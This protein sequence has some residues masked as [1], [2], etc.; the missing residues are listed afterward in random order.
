M[1]VFSTTLVSDTDIYKYI[2]TDTDTDPPWAKMVPAIRPED[3]Q[4]ARNSHD[5]EDVPDQISKPS[6]SL[7]AHS[8]GGSTPQTPGTS[9]PP[10]S[11]GGNA[12]PRR[13]TLKK[14]QFF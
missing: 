2:D 6:K 7:E 5:E 12:T 4:D 8:L 13:K 11:C 10:A 1:E 3:G 9:R 14:N